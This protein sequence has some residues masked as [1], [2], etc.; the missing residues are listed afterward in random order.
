MSTITRKADANLS[1]CSCG[2]TDLHEITRRSTADGKHVVLWSDGSLT[3]ALGYSIRGAWMSPRADRRD[4]A[5]RAGW[6]VLGEVGV[7]DAADV[8]ALSR[9][10]R[11]A[12]DRDGLP[13]TMRARMHRT[14]SGLRPLWAV[15]ATDRDGKPTERVWILPRM[16]PWAGHAVFDYGSRGGHRGRFDLCRRVGLTRGAEDT[17]V[18][19][20]FGFRSQRDLIAWLDQNAPT[21]TTIVK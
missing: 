4:D 5:L 21:I 8:S 11:W 6:L 9:A 18:T 16:G 2:D 15:V 7:Y 13:G 12:A 14:R 10:A 20:G 19:T 17:Y 1:A 3:W